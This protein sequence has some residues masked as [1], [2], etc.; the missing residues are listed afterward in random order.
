MRLSAASRNRPRRRSKTPCGACSEKSCQGTSPRR[1]AAGPRDGDA[2]RLRRPRLAAALLV[3]LAILT[4][5]ALGVLS[6][7]FI[8]VFKRGSPIAWL[9]GA[10]SWLLGGLL[11][12]VAV[13]PDWLRALSALL[14]VPHAIEG[15]RAA[16]LGA[17]PWATLWAT[18]WTR[19]AGTLG[20]S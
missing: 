19:V 12:P 7:S 16:L 5:S 11:Y 2:G 6:P 3:A 10:L 14:P 15:M 8:L 13:L 1:G 18:L 9:F 17:A 20:Q 4:F